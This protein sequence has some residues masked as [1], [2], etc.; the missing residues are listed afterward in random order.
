MPLEFDPATGE[1]FL[2]L[3]APFTNIIITPPRLSDVAPSFV[4]VSSQAIGPWMGVPGLGPGYTIDQA[5]EWIALVTSQT[6]VFVDALQGGAAS[7]PL[8]GCPVRHIREVLEDGTEVYIGAATL[9]RSNFPYIRDAAQKA[10]R[11]A[12]NNALQTGDADIEWHTGYYLAPSHHGRGLM[13][14]VV[15]A[16]ITEV[17][18]PWLQVR[19]I[20]SG[21]FEANAGSL[22]VLQNNGFVVVDRVQTGDEMKSLIVVEWKAPVV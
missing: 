5:E 18:I 16:L 9:I 8:P 11:F 10:R 20:T 13:S 3:P 7:P 17:G 14:A 12:E 4:L 22:K 1:P 15:R 2:R 19:R 6:K 21:A